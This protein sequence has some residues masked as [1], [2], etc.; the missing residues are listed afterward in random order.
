MNGRSKVSTP[1]SNFQGFD[2][3]I[4]IKLKSPNN[5]AYQYKWMGWFPYFP[6]LVG[7][8]CAI[9]SQ[10]IYYAFLALVRLAT[11]KEQPQDF[12]GDH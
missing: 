12:E 8:V 9:C 7:L 11:I 4:E 10:L 1:I 3:V 6:Y 2:T 5:I